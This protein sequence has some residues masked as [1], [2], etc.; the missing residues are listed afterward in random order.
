MC[1]GKAKLYTVLRIKLVSRNLTGGGL[2]VTIG[3]LSGG[4]EKGILVE[5]DKIRL[6]LFLG[7]IIWWNEV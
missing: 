3:S 2:W 7:K 6:L 5:I 4:G 1:S